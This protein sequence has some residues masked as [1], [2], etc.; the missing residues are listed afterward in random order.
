[1]KHD[2]NPVR[3]FCLLLVLFCLLLT[4]CGKKAETA[5][6]PPEATDA[7]LVIGG[8]EV[9]PGVSSLTA[10]LSDGET[11]K[12]SALENLRFLDARGSGNAAEIAAWAKAHPEVDVSFSVTLP[13]GT[14]LDSDAYTADLSAMSSEQVLQAVS[15][16]AL[17]PELRS[18]D[19]GRERAGLA[20]A[21]TDAIRA[22]LPETELHLRF[23]LYGKEFDLADTTLNLRY[24]PVTDNGA[25]VRAVMGHMPNLRKVDMDSCGVDDATMEKLNQDFPDVKVIWRIWFARKYSVRTD[26]EM[27]LASKASVGGEIWDE[28]AAKLYYCH[29]VKYLDIGHNGGITDIGFVR[30]MPKL[31]VAILAMGGWSDASPLADCP[32]LE[33]LEMQTTQ[34]GDLSPLSG[35][36]KLR[37]LNVAKNLNIKDIT[38]LYSLTELERFWLGCYNFVPNEQVE[39][40]H[41][42]APNCVINTSVYDDPTTD[43]WRYNDWEFT[44]RYALLRVQFGGYTDQAFSFTWN[45]PLYPKEGEGVIPDGH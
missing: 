21:D 11:E 15:Q 13:D 39:E 25:A 22:Q 36:T 35:L 14:V 43:H 33:Y 45:D 42:R 16:L 18:V 23:P 17:L 34:C 7:A 29:D 28:D 1:M 26:V 31:E 3:T 6:A 44:D 37:H 12:L 38:P 2:L 10:V 27:I 8:L 5:V 9:D 4:G 40:M 30:G 32:N 41:R 19:L 20:P 24:I